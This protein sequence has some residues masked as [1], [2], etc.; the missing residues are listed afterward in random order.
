MLASRMVCSVYVIPPMNTILAILTLSRSV[1][2][3]ISYP[4]LKVFGRLDETRH[5]ACHRTMNSWEL[6]NHEKTVTR[7]PKTRQWSMINGQCQRTT[8][9]KVNYLLDSCALFTGLLVRECYLEH[10]HN[11]NGNET[12]R[13]QRDGRLL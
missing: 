5:G 10:E 1:P 3:T 12:R 6:E 13:D 2:A 4:C 9:K 7:N 8:L 11:S